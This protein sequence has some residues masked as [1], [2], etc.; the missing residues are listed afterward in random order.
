M[1]NNKY[2]KSVGIIVM[3]M[4]V[5]IVFYLAVVIASNDTSN[6]EYNAHVCAVYGMKPD[7][8]TPLK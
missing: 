2:L 5:L 8:T 7:C 4:L 6:R 3:L 1:K